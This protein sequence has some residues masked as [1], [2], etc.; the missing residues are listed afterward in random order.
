MVKPDLLPVELALL[1]GG[2][3]ASDNQTE[4]AKT[5]ERLLC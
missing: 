3:T 2:S 1:G 5:K 4:Q